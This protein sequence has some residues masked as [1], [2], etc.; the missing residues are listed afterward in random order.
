[1]SHESRAMKN[2]GCPTSFGLCHHLSVGIEMI[3]KLIGQER[4]GEDFAMIVFLF[5][6]T[7]LTADSVE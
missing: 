7:S 6:T 1:M 4:F 5:C 2:T 3:P